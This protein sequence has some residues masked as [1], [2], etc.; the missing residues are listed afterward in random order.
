MRVFL[1]PV[2]VMAAVVLVPVI[3]FLV[4]GEKFENQVSEWIR[5]DVPTSARFAAVVGALTVDI[6]L[7]IPSSAVSTWA[8]GVLGIGVAIAA[9]SIGMTLGAIL[10]FALARWLGRP[11]VSRFSSSRD[12]NSLQRAS[13]QY[14]SLAL[15]I[16]RPL[17]ILAEACVLLTGGAQLAWSRF[18]PPVIAANLVISGGYAITGSISGQNESLMTATVLSGTIPLLVA[19]AARRWLWARFA[20]EDSKSSGKSKTETQ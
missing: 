1:K 10:G 8:G 5:D 17:P 18:L 7:P 15:L 11:F 4:L 12:V 13:T 20:T 9:S 14:G 16:T 3:P 19:L 2:L 6:F